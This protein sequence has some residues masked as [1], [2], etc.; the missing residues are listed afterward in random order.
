MPKTSGSFLRNR[1]AVSGFTLLELLV[2]MA[3]IAMLAG[4]VAP[5]ALKAVEAA[6]RR[7]VA[8]DLKFV[9]QSLPV[10]AFHSGEEL[11]LDAD[12]LRKL[13]PEF[14]ADWGMLVRPKLHYSNTGIA[15]AAEVKLLPPGEA[16]TLTFRILPVTGEVVEQ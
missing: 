1:P 11:N 7:G 14:P 16:V 12:A 13:Q 2:V 10:R 6:K 5:N 4:L 9:L 3:L 8:A 15:A